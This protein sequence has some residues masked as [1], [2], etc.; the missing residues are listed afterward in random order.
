MHIAVNTAHQ[1]RTE[2]EACGRAEQFSYEALGLLFDYLEEIA[3]DYELDV[4]GLC[5][6]YSEDS[7]EAIAAANGIDLPDNEDEI[8][9]R[10]IVRDYLEN[11]TSVVG[12]TPSS[13][14]YAQF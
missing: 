2:F 4:I 10:E 5:C 8:E 14:I 6:D 11:H 13:I 9:H 3:P 1:F 12:E 7:P